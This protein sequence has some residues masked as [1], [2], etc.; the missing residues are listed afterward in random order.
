MCGLF[1]FLSL[2]FFFFHSRSL[3]ALAADSS[4][5]R[6]VWREAPGRR[7]CGRRKKKKKKM[8]WGVGGEE[9]A[10]HRSGGDPGEAKSPGLTV[11]KWRGVGCSGDGGRQ[12]AKC[13]KVPV[14]H[15]RFITP[16]EENEKKRLAGGPQEGAVDP[17]RRCRQ[18]ERHARACTCAQFKSGLCAKQ[19]FSLFVFKGPVA[20]QALKYDS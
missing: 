11:L 2:F 8:G 13:R 19:A 6:S 16:A 5:L 17:H 3:F 12:C 4:L 18:K 14:L 15:V 20:F 9:R 7:G 10:R 1:Y